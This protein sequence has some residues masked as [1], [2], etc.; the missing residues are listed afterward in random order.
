MTDGSPVRGSYRIHTLGCKTNLYDS[1]RLAE[2]LE[3]VGLRPADA[4]EAPDVCIVNSCTV[5][6]TAGSKTR[7][8]ASRLARRYPAALVFVTG[9]YASASPAELEAIEGVTAVVP[10]D[11]WSAILKAV[12]PG[13]LPPEYEHFNGDFGINC[14][15]GRARAFLKMQD[16]CN[17]YC[18]YCIIPHVR[19]RSRSRNLDGALDEARRLIDEGFREIVL[20]G[21]HLGLYGREQDPPIDLARAVRAMADLPG[22]GRLRLSSLEGL[23]VDDALLDAMRHPAVCAHLHLPLQSGD[24]DVLRRMNRRYSPAE[25]Q[26]VVETARRRL[27][28]PAITTDVIAGFPGE[29]EAAF[30]NTLRVIEALRFS[31]LHVFPFSPRAGTPAAGMDGQVTPEV[32]RARVGI[33][34]EL[35][36]KLAA[37]WATGFVGR[38]ARV[39]FERRDRGGMLRGYTDRYVPV[40]VSGSADLTGEIRM[41]TGQD[42]RGS[43]LVAQLVQ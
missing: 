42:H 37:E 10:R 36:E 9:C 32:A 20:T 27:D 14:F 31:R 6:S 25:F 7:K 28:R 15:G 21:I 22:L 35:G 4:T 18:S 17:S 41:V 24:A 16:G 11:D 2:A 13:G 1:R 26:R 8:T 34:T 38:E 19:G 39:L 43:E 3:A 30:V 12:C 29:S 5:T 40:R 23:E 33:L